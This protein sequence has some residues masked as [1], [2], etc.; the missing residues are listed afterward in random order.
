MQG[1]EAVQGADAPSGLEAPLSI[2]MNGSTGG[3]GRVR[4]PDTSKPDAASSAPVS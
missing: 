4:S 3:K 1:A 2:G